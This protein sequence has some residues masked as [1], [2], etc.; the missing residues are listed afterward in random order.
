VG[1]REAKILREHLR[2]RERESDR[3][4]QKSFSAAFKNTTVITLI[5]KGGEWSPISLR[6]VG[7]TKTGEWP[8]RPPQSLPD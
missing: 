7:I 4:R 2:R 1:R 8:R 6:M 5:I 3:E